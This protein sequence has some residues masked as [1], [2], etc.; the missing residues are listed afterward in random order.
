[1]AALHPLVAASTGVQ[2]QLPLPPLVV[3]SACFGA[4]C[5]TSSL[6]FLLD[7]GC[8]F[9]RSHYPILFFDSGVDV[10]DEDDDVMLI[11]VS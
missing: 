9:D 11:L 6:T 8:E 1:M 4:F 7:L 3:V 2:L 5:R 10:C